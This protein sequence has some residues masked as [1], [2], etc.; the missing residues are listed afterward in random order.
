MDT[1]IKAL[2]YLP[3]DVSA[4]FVGRGDFEPYRHLAKK[5]N[6][7]ERVFNVDHVKNVDLPVWYSWCD[8]FCTPSRWEGFGFVFIEA[9][10]CKASII[11]SDIGP[12]NEYLTNEKDSILVKEYENPLAIANAINYVLDNENEVK[13]LKNNARLVGEHFSKEYVDSQEIAIYEEII[14]AGVKSRKK[15]PFLKRKKLE[16]K[17]RKY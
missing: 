14:K 17:Y 15:L 10:S 3:K 6:V 2:Q 4:I 16:W 11:T 5:Y 7:L 1:L 8:C 9:A 12:M 13:I